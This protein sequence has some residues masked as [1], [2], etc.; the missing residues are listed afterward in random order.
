MLKRSHLM[1]KR[2]QTPHVS[3]IIFSILIRI[4]RHS[5][6]PQS[7]LSIRT[8]SSRRKKDSSVFTLATFLNFTSYRFSY[9]SHF[10]PD[11]FFLKKIGSS[12]SKGLPARYVQVP[13]YH[14]HPHSSQ[15]S[16]SWR[17]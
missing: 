3:K 2:S 6:L 16:S 13:E 7:S 9:S 12:G 4:H 14:T 17:R 1:L 11:F 8:S 15:P 10:F 5:P